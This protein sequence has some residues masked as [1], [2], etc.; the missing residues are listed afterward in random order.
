MR[1]STPKSG[2]LLS[3]PEALE[4]LPVGRTLFYNML[5]AGAI[6][7]ANRFGRSWVIHWETFMNAM[8]SGEVNWESA[9]EG[10]EEEPVWVKT[11]V[12]DGDIPF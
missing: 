11:A 7:G 9:G 2:E 8:A 3:A 6:P 10:G 5:R 12:A 4:L 1:M